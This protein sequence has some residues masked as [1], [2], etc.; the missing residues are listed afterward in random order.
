MIIANPKLNIIPHPAEWIVNGH[1]PHAVIPK[2][3]LPILSVNVTAINPAIKPIV[4]PALVRNGHQQIAISAGHI[5]K[6]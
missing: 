4:T 3:S 1:L 6:P 5:W 2:T